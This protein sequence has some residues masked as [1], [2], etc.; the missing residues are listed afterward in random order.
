MVF[1]QKQQNDDVA[2]VLIDNPPVNALSTSVA[3][4]LSHAI[5]SAENDTSVRAVVVIGQGK[6]FV[7]GADI[8]QLEEMAWTHSSGPPSLHKLLLQIEDCTK[9]VVMAI[10]GSALGGVLELAMSGHY[11]VATRDAQVG[12]QK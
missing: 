8:K 1:T 3:D 12:N 9:P 5:Q 4:G 2:I 10:H 11:R 7:V 6:T